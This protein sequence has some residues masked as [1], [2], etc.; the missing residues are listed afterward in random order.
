MAQKIK[1]IAMMSRR[2]TPKAVPPAPSSLAATVM[3]E[4]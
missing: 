3:E 2:T 4:T 1:A